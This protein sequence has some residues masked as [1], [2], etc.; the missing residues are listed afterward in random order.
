MKG[1]EE[2][3]RGKERDVCS[4]PVFRQEGRADDQ[5]VRGRGQGALR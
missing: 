1:G 3:G 4:A 5:G 2:D